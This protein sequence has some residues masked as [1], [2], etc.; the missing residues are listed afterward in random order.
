MKTNIYQVHLDRGDW[1]ECNTEY[2]EVVAANSE[3][4][5]I[6]QALLRFDDNKR[7]SMRNWNIYAKLCFTN[8]TIGS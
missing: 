1:P 7:N 6:E 3:E 2:F 4:E 8:V 5:A